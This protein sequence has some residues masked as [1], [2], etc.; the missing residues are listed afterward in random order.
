MPVCEIVNRNAKRKCTFRK[1]A[2][3]YS[4]KRLS[5]PRTDINLAR[6]DT[7]TR[8]LFLKLAKRTNKHLK[9]TKFK[10]LHSRK[11]KNRSKNDTD[12]TNACSTKA[13]VA[14]NFYSSRTLDTVSSLISRAAWLR[15]RR[16][17]SC[18]NHDHMILGSNCTLVILLRLWMR[19]FTMIISAWWLRTT[20]KFMIKE[21]KR[22]NEKWSIP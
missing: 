2:Y 5:L 12:A 19:R 21:V 22:K 1:Y 10:I 4:S 6:T 8:R 3:R 14:L 20:S 13:K 15:S 16:R 7:F 18:N 9:T 17:R 11:K